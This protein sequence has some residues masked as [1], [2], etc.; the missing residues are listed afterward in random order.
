[1]GAHNSK[2]PSLSTCPT[3]Q[4]QHKAADL[5]VLARTRSVL[6]QWDDAAEARKDRAE[7]PAIFADRKSV[8]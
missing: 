1:M 2:Q 6:P 4:S 8:V 7:V 5:L 3:T